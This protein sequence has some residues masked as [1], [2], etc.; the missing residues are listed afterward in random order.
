[1]AK[2]SAAGLL[3]VHG[4]GSDPSIFSGWHSDFP[5]VQVGT[6]DLHAGL[7]VAA[8]SMADYAAAV[9]AAAVVLPR[10]LVLCGWSMGGLVALLAA[11][12]VRPEGLVMIEPSP[13]AEVQGFTDVPLGNG[14]FDPEAVYGAF[15]AGA[16]PRPE[17]ELAR[18]ERKR[19]ISIPRL[20]C[21]S[22]VI[23]GY[24]FAEERG[25][26]IAETY[27]AERITFPDLDHWGLVS[28]PDVRAA[29]RA[30]VETLALG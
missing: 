25:T 17:S 11:G 19:G 4:A 18:S 1:M 10:P 3:L 26:R 23:H 20:D 22:L 13:P 24:E 8:A 27:H 21:A 29:V 16:T 9:E 2:A 30:F 15:P 5:G 6:V 14:V 12:A 28:D 7:N